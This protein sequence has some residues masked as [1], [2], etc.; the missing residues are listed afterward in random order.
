MSYECCL[1]ECMCRTHVAARQLEGSALTNRCAAWH[2][3]THQHPEGTDPTDTHSRSTR[4]VHASAECSSRSHIHKTAATVIRTKHRAKYCLPCWA[5]LIPSQPSAACHAGGAS[6]GHQPRLQNRGRP[7]LQLGPQPNRLQ[8]QD[9]ALLPP[10]A[11]AARLGPRLRR[12]SPPRSMHA[13]E[14]AGCPVGPGV[15]P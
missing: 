14:S 13:S 2:I 9:R 6:Y 7:E 10:R 1:D 15:S 3:L 5:S 11:D 4:S 12:T 8:C